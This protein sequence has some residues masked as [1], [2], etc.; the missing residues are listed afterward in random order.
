MC[1]KSTSTAQ[2]AD[3]HSYSGQSASATNVAASQRR[4]RMLKLIDLQFIA[5]AAAVAFVMGAIL[6]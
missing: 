6:G 3:A 1:T 5:V 2:T 4:S